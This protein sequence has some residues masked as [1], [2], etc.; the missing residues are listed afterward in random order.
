MRRIVLSLAVLSVLTLGACSGGGSVLNIGGNTTVDRVIITTVGP[1][2]VA[3]VLPGAAIP[4]SATAVRGGQNG[5]VNVNQFIWS[6]AVTA[7]ATY[8]S[9]ELG[10]TKPCSTLV[11]T[12]GGGGTPVAFLP[13]YTIYI[14]I[15]PTN[16]SNV[17][18]VPPTTIPLPT[19]APAGSTI[20]IANPAF[21][22]VAP[23]T[24]PYCVVVT[25]TPRGGN[26]A[27]AGSIIV[28]VVNPAA[29]LN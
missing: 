11:Y 12:P 17:L 23:S 18:F 16:E 8:P 19:G 14:T 21:P 4:L 6:A 1:S 3:R 2:N 13:D 28:A 29:P 7:G 20:T 5:V 24:N 25:A 15:D 22:P 10:G 27:N 9:N 26:A